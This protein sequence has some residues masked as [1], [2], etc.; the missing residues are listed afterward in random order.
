MRSKTI[1]LNTVSTRATAGS[2]SRRPYAKG[3]V[4]PEPVIGFGTRTGITYTFA[5][6]GPELVV[7][8]GGGRSA[9]RSPSAAGA[10][11][12]MVSFSAPNYLGPVAELK[13]VLTDMARTGQL[14]GVL[15]AAGGVA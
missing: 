8:N 15:R 13:R 10:G 5:E 1:Y 9:M 3:G 12:V 11:P 2:S 14:A 6:D 4:I 7:P